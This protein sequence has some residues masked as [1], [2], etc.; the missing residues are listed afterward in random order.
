[1]P[2]SLPSRRVLVADDNQDAAETT[3]DVLR[4][5]GYEVMIAYDGKQAVEVARLFQPD[6][7]ILDINMPVM[8]G[9][10]AA[11][12]IRRQHASVR[13]LVLIALTGRADPSDQERSRQAGF[14]RHLTK[15]APP[16][17]LCVLLDTYFDR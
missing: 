13:R 8:D 4:L 7:A 5:G 14:D 15:P 2:A 9:Y 1:M 16:M 10:E 17:D 3:A 12:E 11:S 6:A